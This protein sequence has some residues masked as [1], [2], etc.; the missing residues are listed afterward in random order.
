MTELL[1][2]N[3]NVSSSKISDSDKSNPPKRLFSLDFFRGFT[4]LILIGSSTGLYELMVNS[5]NSFI[6]A[7]GWQFEHRYW[8]GITLWDFVEP[9]F[10]FIVGVAIPF[11][12]MNR[13]E[14]GNSKRDIFWHALKR[15]G[16]LFFLGILDYSISAGQPVWKL[17]SVL[18]QLSVIYL[19]AVFFVSKPIRLQLFVSFLLL[20][21]S[22]FLYQFWP[23]EGFN[24][25]YVPDNNF[26]SWFDLKVMGILET[27]HWVSFNVI[28]TAAF[29]I[30]GAVSGL[31]LR[32][33]RS[34]Q[35]KIKILL[36]AGFIGIVTGLILE[37][38][39][40]MIKRIATVSVIIETGGWCLVVLAFSYWLV[41]IQKIQK[42]PRFFAIV[43]MNPLFIYLFAQ[44]GGA[45]FLTRIVK[46]FAYGLFSWIGE[47]EVEYA[48]ALL[49]WFLL[50]YL[51]FWL[52]KNKIFIKI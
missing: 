35:E 46:P 16:V 37:P 1:Y 6:S 14:K 51:C 17:W 4:M 44:F 24:Q 8:A 43:G 41:D 7:I 50:W 49:V 48:I 29:A 33:D 12:V 32:S 28:P 15:A 38:F 31:L 30:W 40:P 52:Y 13:L 3:T 47:K 18:T 23:I 20:F 10:M 25:P 42:I 9:F 21:I 45:R 11:S 39:V 34:Y 2:K 22:F 36:I 26:G 27:D 5:D 19:I